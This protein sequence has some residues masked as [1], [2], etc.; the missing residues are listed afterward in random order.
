MLGKFLR[1]IYHACWYVFAAVV[2]T[3]AVA[4]TLVRLLLPHVGEY[5]EELQ[6]LIS[7]QTGYVVTI[8][9]IQGEW[10]GW[11]PSLYLYG[12]QVTTGSREQD[13]TRLQSAIM[14]FDPFSSFREG[15]LTPF[16]LTIAG[17]ELTVIRGDDGSLRITPDKTDTVVLGPGVTNTVFID[18]LLLQKIIT[19]SGATLRFLDAARENNPVLVTNVDLVLMNSVSH[20]QLN[21]SMTLPG[22]YG[23]KCSFALDIYGDISTPD[24]SGQMYLDGR[25][26]NLGA[27]LPHLDEKTTIKVSGAPVDIRLWSTWQNARLTRINGA[28]EA[29]GVHLAKGSS[30]L[31]IRQIASLFTFTR[32]TERGLRLKLKMKELRT[33]NGDWPETEISFTSQ[34]REDGKQSR[35]LL[36]SNYLN[37]RDMF[38]IAGDNIVA[39]DPVISGDT[40]ISGSL[41]DCLIVYDPE[42]PQAE[43]LAID[44]RFQGLNVQNN[45]HKV[46]LQQLQGSLTGTAGYGRLRLDTPTSEMTLPGMLNKTYTFNELQGDVHW[47][48]ENETLRIE[49]ANL[50]AHSPHFDARLQGSIL[51]T[52]GQGLPFADLLFSVSELDLENLQYYLPEVVPERTRIWIRHALVAGYTSTLDMVLRGQLADFPFD[53]NE[54][55]FEVIADIHNGTLDYHADWIPADNIEAELRID[56]RALSVDANSGNIYNAV[57]T[58]ARAVIE[59]LGADDNAVTIRGEIKGQAKDALNFI[60]NTPL[61][62]S[63]LLSEVLRHEID[64]P[65]KLDLE[66][67]I[68]F[69]HM[70]ITYQGNIHFEDTVF[71]STA[72]GIN[73]DHI[74]GGI[75]FDDTAVA[76]DNLTASYAGEP[77]TLVINAGQQSLLNFGLAG[78]SGTSFIAGQLVH[79]FPDLKNFTKQL[80]EYLDGSCDWT[81]MLS[82]VTDVTNPL[83]AES[84][85]LRITSTLSG[86]TINLPAP[87]GKTGDPLSLEVNTIISPASRKNIQFAYG[88]VLN[89]EIV[90]DKSSPDILS[91][92]ELA[93]GPDENLSGAD[94]GISVHGTVSELSLSDWYGF[95]HN[96]DGSLFNGPTKNLR[97]EISAG[98][99]GLLGH[100]YADMRFSLLNEPSEWHVVLGGKEIDGNVF[101]PKGG[102]STPVRGEFSSINI[103]ATVAS[104]TSSEMDPASVPPLQFTVDQFT[105]RDFNLGKLELLTT[106]MADGM[107]IDKISFNKPELQITG[108]GKWSAGNGNQVSEFALDLHADTLEAMLTTFKY[109]NEPVKDGTSSFK[110]NAQWPGAP[111]DYNLAG[112]AGTLIMEIDRGLF[113]NIEPKAGRLFGLLNLQSLIRLLSLDFTVLFS[114]GFAFDNIAGT[115]TIEAGNAY[116]NNLAIKGRSADITVTGRTGLID[117]DYDQIATVNPHTLFGPVGLG[118]EAVM[119][120]TGGL[121]EF[122]PE[123]FDKLLRYQYT[124]KGSWDNPVIEKYNS[125]Y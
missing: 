108:N 54:G 26:L 36:H 65:F 23:E 18:W 87:L 113:L 1:R 97:M 4:I 49:T 71:K 32:D 110:L 63:S 22:D 61:S 15:Q 35:Y 115:F 45:L 7:K 125:E 66:F 5:R 53:N 99:L 28:F 116:T 88:D 84:N 41:L 20:M 48:A 90:L 21:G 121:F 79:F 42:M 57:I 12:I 96:L 69:H 17:P 123:T 78:H 13:I 120:I 103:G 8:D 2:L 100:R 95:F 77:V 75:S 74:A 56:G 104:T 73:L 39:M 10:E 38:T 72:L 119:L 51:Y 47:H 67:H 118:V 16:H 27:W 70:P 50:Q 109:S 19:I 82:P 52:T 25:R 102:E 44:G 85:V 24:W 40:D 59:D 3:S 37:I 58:E 114:K 112:I 80:E 124:I 6:T 94:S 14:R 92:L 89:G 86:L 34:P 98:T 122:I 107:S 11:V 117:K 106:P 101:I 29:A 31:D 83:A 9:T 60:Q 33:V 81:A 68:P 76:T 46:Q 64:G 105:Y 111:T 62:T 43:R 91:R 55:R 93:L 30:Q